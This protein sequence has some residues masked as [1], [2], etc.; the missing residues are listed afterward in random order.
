MVEA[1]EEF[2]EE[3]EKFL[4]NYDTFVSVAER[5]LGS[6]FNSEDYPDVETLRSKFV[7]AFKKETISEITRSTDIRLEVSDKMK[8]DIQRE[9]ENK[10]KNNVK[11]VFKVT[12]DALLEQ[13]NHIVDKLKKGER[14]HARSFDKLRQSVDMLPSIN[15][16]ILGNDQ[17][18]TNTHQG[19]LTVLASINSYDSLRDDSDVGEA[20]RKK[21]ADDLEKSVGD[22][23]G[24][25]LDKAFGGSND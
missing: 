16:D 15:S 13:V 9:A 17:D 21:V 24:S 22:L 25:F 19:L 4:Q 2:Y 11:N 23:K 12:V 3:A 7:F 20:K 10:I 8:A 18:I 1:K 14:F 6:A 5:K